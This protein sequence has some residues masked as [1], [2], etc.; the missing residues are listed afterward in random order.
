M[1]SPK[2]VA[3]LMGQTEAKWSTRLFHKMALVF[4]DLL[5]NNKK[6]YILVYDS[7]DFML[8]RD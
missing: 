2:P 8:F 1:N 4:R 7:L 6:E 3:N 5:K